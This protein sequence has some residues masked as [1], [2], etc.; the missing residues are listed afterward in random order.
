MLFEHIGNNGFHETVVVVG[1]EWDTPVD[2]M[3]QEF[4]DTLTNSM[5][6]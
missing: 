6:G 3:P 1:K 2:P 5:H 4:A